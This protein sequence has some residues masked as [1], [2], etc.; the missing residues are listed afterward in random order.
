MSRATAV[1]PVNM[2][3]MTRGSATSAAPTA[4]APGT[5]WS[6]S[7]GTPAAWRIRTASA[8]TRGVSSAGLASTGLPA[9]SAAATWPVKIASGKF[10]GLMHT[11][12]PSGAW[13]S[14]PKVRTSSAP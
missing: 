8:A 7:A 4:P 12:G 2:T 14:A 11:T 9:A 3:P 1:E 13:R 5:S 6:A 10:Q